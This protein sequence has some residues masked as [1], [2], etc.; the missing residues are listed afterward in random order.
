MTEQAIAR[1]IKDAKK[2]KRPPS[3]VRLGKDFR[4]TASEVVDLGLET[5]RA[6]TVTLEGDRVRQARRRRNAGATRKRGRPA[7]DLSPE[8]KMAHIRAQAAERKRRSRMS[9]KNSHASSYIRRMERDEFSVTLPSSTDLAG[10]NFE[11]F[12]IIAIRLM[13]GTDVL[14]EWERG[15]RSARAFTPPLDSAPR[16]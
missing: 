10:I 5:I 1:I 12:G 6:F 9:R 3:A 4:V 2:A 8:K 11:K 13:R 7:L 15:A 14:R 16:G